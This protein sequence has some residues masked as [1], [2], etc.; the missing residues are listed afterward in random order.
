MTYEE[1]LYRIEALH[2]FGP[3][4]GLERI[5]KL[6]NKLGNP[7]ND[8]RFIHV[9]GTNGKGTTCTL[10]ASVLHCAGYRTG[11]FVSPHVADFRERLQIDGQMI[12]KE[13][14]VSLADRVFP[15]IREMELQG[16]GVT[17]FEA[18]TAMAL[19]WYAQKK[20]DIVVLEVGLGGRLD[21]TNI[22]PTPLVSVI[23]SISLDHTKILGDTVEQIAYEKCGIIKENGVTVSYPSQDI[24]ALKVIRKIAAER[25]NRFVD[26]AH[27]GVAEISAGLG[28]TELLWHHVR[29][30][31]PFLG[32]HQVKNAATALSVLNVLR[33]MGYTI[34]NESIQQG[35]SD[36]VLPARFEVLARSPI[37]IL[38]GAHN[39]A[40][41]AALA[42]TIRRY[43][44]G[45]D[46]VAVMGMLQDKDVD[47]A[48]RNLSGLF[49]C[50]I[51]TEPPS[52]RAL[53]ADA[54]AQRWHQLGTCAEPAA[55]Y[56]AALRMADE[57]IK[58]GGAVVICG[59]LYLAGELRFRALQFWNQS[60]K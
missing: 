4:P 36:A 10:L 19:L 42:K 39:P 37:V 16:D 12:A 49:S 46:I 51:T 47:T 11:L 38:D 45:R 21:A 27:A 30:K 25:S 43:L 24:K 2:Q 9:A 59:S 13:E 56:D 1:I 15:I 29:L 60:G 55:G 52:P 58:P 31:L 44:A 18:V 8:L 6:M 17:E 50:V 23:T 35:F 7:Q 34:S 5:G 53:P 3:R 40:G 32:R 28:G 54:L 14:L 22:I 41:T 20:C 26:A 48:L 33:E 57:R